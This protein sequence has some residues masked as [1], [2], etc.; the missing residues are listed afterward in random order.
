[1]SQLAG[2]KRISIYLSSFTNRYQ[3][4][5]HQPPWALEGGFSLL[6]PVPVTWCRVVRGA[7]NPQGP[8]GRV[9]EG[10]EISLCALKPWD[11]VHYRTPPR[12]QLF[13]QLFCRSYRG[14]RSGQMPSQEGKGQPGA[15]LA[16]TSPAA[17]H[18][19]CSCFVS[20]AGLQKSW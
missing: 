3:L 7:A 1:M 11:R 9:E 8:S 20:P 17:H 18:A 5:L 4:Y 13:P 15:P 2:V 14:R 12:S 16:A 19:A 6:P 10:C